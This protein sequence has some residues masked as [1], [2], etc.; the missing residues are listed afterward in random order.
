[1]DSEPDK[2]LKRFI[3]F[4]L[5]TT[6][7]CTNEA[8]LGEMGEFPLHLH[9]LVSLLKF[10]H[11]VSNMNEQCLVRKALGTHDNMQTDWIC[12]VHFMLNYLN[13]GVTLTQPRL[14]ST[15][16]FAD[17]CIQRIKERFI[18]EWRERLNNQNSKLRTY[19]LF[20]ESF[21]KET[22]LENV[23]DFQMRKSITKFRCSDHHLEI[24]IGRHKKIPEPL[25]TCKICCHEIE[26]EK[27]FLCSCPGYKAI[28]AHYFYQEVINDHSWID[29]LKCKEK[30]TAYKLGNFLTKSFKAREST[31]KLNEHN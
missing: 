1:M 28:R 14:T 16:T 15:K 24:E 31:L 26:N 27:H 20:K 8:I 5:G 22:Y 25:R 4:I 23:T 11:R 9:N 3:K 2:V 19:G 18:Q 7:S 13:M 12:T 21:E 29:I 30:E 10:W 6:R 17:L